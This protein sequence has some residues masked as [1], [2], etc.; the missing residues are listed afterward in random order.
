MH[1]CL[2][3]YCLQTKFGQ[4]NVFTPVCHSVHRK[5]GVSAPWHAGIHPPLGQQTPPFLDV[6]PSR[7]TPPPNTTG[8]GQQAD[9][10][11]PTGMHTCCCL[12][13][14][15]FFL[16]LHLLL[17]FFWFCCC[18]CCLFSLFFRTVHLKLVKVCTWSWYLKDS[19][20]YI[21]LVRSI[22][23]QIHILL[24]EYFNCR[25]RIGAFNFKRHIFCPY[26]TWSIFLQK[27][28]LSRT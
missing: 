2:C 13:Y 20:T 15:S 10:M 23:N 8:Y 4:G 16:S 12:F 14:F 11:H 21:V 1:S 25:P 9:G 5:W 28:F 7:Q 22:N 24:F 18:C 27:R 17:F 3:Y 26:L 6:H 19:E